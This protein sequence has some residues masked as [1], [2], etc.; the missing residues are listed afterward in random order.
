MFFLRS[1]VS[2][3]REIA[4]EAEKLESEAQRRE[5]EWR[6]LQRQREEEHRERVRAYEQIAREQLRLANEQRRLAEEQRKQAEQIA[7]HNEQIAKLEFRMDQAE[8]D[9]AHWKET[10]S[11]LYALLDLEMAEQAAVVP[12]SKTDIKCQKRIIALR[13]QIHAAE[14]RYSK[15]KFEKEQA[16]IKLGA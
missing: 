5:R 11:N 2:V 3:Q 10:V 14:S 7:K 6:E 12:G 1:K 16:Q 9:I 4:Y 8:A 13:N 15:A